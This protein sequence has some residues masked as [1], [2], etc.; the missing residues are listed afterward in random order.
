MTQRVLIVDDEKPLARALELKL[1]H[2]GLDAKAVFNGADAVALL[3]SEQ[4]GLVL[5]DLVMP[6]EDGFKVLQDIQDMHL[7]TVVIVSSNL[8]QEEDIARAKSLGA[9]DYFIKSDTTLADIV[10]KVKGYL[11]H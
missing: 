8:S 9:I 6:Q 7:K 1:T 11:T 10:Q 2:E 3:K 5:L 4:F